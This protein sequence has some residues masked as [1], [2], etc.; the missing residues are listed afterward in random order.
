MQIGW[1]NHVYFCVW[2]KS[3]ITFGEGF[4]RV[5]LQMDTYDWFNRKEKLTIEIVNF[6]LET[7]NCHPCIWSNTNH[8][9]HIWGWCLE[10]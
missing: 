9:E 6:R 2:Q 7:K 3:V 10:V 1:W 4:T 8:K 5:K